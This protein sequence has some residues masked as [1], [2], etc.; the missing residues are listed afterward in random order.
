MKFTAAQIA[1]LVNGKVEGDANTWV[2]NIE[3]IE[4]GKI[5]I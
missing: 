1:L 4:Y 2:S 3:K 5:D